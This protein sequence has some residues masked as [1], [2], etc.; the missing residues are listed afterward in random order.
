MLAQHLTGWSTWK[1]KVRWHPCVGL[2]SEWL[3]HTW[4][5]VGLTA[6]LE[7]MYSM[8]IGGGRCILHSKEEWGTTK[9]KD[10]VAKDIVMVTVRQ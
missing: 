7:P 2:H 3:P 8:S 9:W 10:V 1:T 4:V 6:M 5:N